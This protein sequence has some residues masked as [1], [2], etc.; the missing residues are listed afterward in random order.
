MNK[1]L[2]RVLRC[3]WS[4][5]INLKLQF[6]LYFR[7]SKPTFLPQFLFQHGRESI[8]GSYFA[9]PVCVCVSLSLC[10]SAWTRAKY[11]PYLSDWESNAPPK[12]P[13]H[14]HSHRPMCSAAMFAGPQCMCCEQHFPFVSPSTLLCISPQPRPSPLHVCQQKVRVL[15]VSEAL[16][17]GTP[18]QC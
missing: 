2:R 3:L 11:F 17:A 16:D 15:P 5:H 9:N 8:H 7:E 4:F 14:H 18:A 10:V 1:Q 13:L 12:L 6:N